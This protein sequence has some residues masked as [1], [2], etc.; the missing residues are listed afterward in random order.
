MV[1]RIVTLVLAMVL[2]LGLLPGTSWLALPAEAAVSAS[3]YLSS[4]TLSQ[5]HL[6]LTVKKATTLKTLPCSAGTNSNSANVRTCAVG[7]T[8]TATGLM[9]NP[10]GNYWYRVQDGS[11]TC[12]VYSA[13]TTVKAQLTSDLTVSS[14]TVPK[15]VSFGKDFA[16]GGTL[17]DTY[18]PNFI[19]HGY[20]YAG[21]L[22]ASSTSTKEK[23]YAGDSTTN[24]S[25]KL[26]SSKIDTGLA[27]NTLPSGNYTYIVNVVS[28]NYYSTDGKTLSAHNFN[29]DVIVQPFTVG[30]YLS[31]CT[32]YNTYLKVQVLNKLYTTLKSLPCSKDTTT[33]STDVRTSIIG[34][35]LTVTGLYR[36]TQGN[37]W[38]R[39]N[40]NGTTCYL[41]AGDAK[42]LEHLTSDI[43]ISSVSAPSSLTQG[44]KFSIK[45]KIASTNNILSRVEAY[46]YPGTVSGYNASVTPKLSAGENI[47]AKS[48]SLQNS[49]IDYSLTFGKLTNGK[50]TYVIRAITPN[51]YSADGKTLS[52]AS[53]YKDLVV[54]AFTVGTPS[55]SHTTVTD[56]G[57]AATCTAAGKTDGS[58]CSKCQEVLTEQTVIPATG[59]TQVSVA[60]YAATCTAAGK[61]DGVSC[62]VC[63]A[64]LTAQTDIPAK[65]HT[66]TTV[67]GTDATCTT[68]GKTDGVSCSVCKAVLTAQTDIPAKG[69][70]KTT[71]K[72]TDATC[73]TA[74][75]TDGVSCSVCKA[76]LTAQTDIPAKGHTKTTDKGYAA[77]CTEAGKTDGSHCSVCNTVLT[78]QETIAA[79]GHSFGEWMPTEIANIESRN[80][81]NCEHYEIRDVSQLTVEA[82]KV[83]SSNSASS[84]K[85]KVSWNE[86]ENAAKYQVYRATSRSGKYSLM[87]T[88]SGTTYTNTSAKAG[89]TYYYYVVA[90]SE[91]GTKSD[92]SNTVSRTCDLAQPTVTLTG[93]S[94]SGKIKVS[95]K[96]VDGADEYKVYRATS[97]NGTYT[98]MKTTTG[99]SYTNTGAKTGTTYYYKVRAIHENS[100][101]NSAYSSIKSRTCDLPRPDVEIS[102]TK[103]GSPKLTWDAIDG[104][105][106]YKVYR[107]TSKSGTYK[108]M[109][110][111]TGTSYTNSS[112]VEGKTY[113]Y[114]VRAI[115]EKS[116]ANSAYSTVKSIKAK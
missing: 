95:W 103:G 24:S 93:I 107:A 15:T 21:T 22:S 28:A 58:H 72:G 31:E 32:F 99:T 39:V 64:V 91:N 111:T 27:F 42:V 77:T 68:A 48:Y 61:T 12:Y 89:R 20:V 74:G 88:V 2:C 13:D 10:S 67:K 94:S 8:L 65:G 6:T 83:K 108:L 105:E 114:K 17:K 79:L 49:D 102:L 4:C 9:R 40:D 101:A 25:Y 78:A 34:E 53:L 70:T 11:T 47:S 54:K 43:T 59:H 36:N 112:A 113:Y 82:P 84:G 69:H 45:G 37:Y 33:Y 41:Y 75:K 57:Y 55:C 1:K 52:K 104:A 97:K 18:H 96:A 19:V 16:I 46:V 35:T 90:V 106:E 85:P 73:T 86:V 14:L 60:G 71:V 56:K 5:T 80:C 109:K 23:L 116:A 98:L 76:V 51:Y 66:K 44:S 7:D 62:S 50:Y 30:S 100:S 115:H 110:T 3:S 63:K 87:K 81:A 26:G 38:Y 29:K 92:K